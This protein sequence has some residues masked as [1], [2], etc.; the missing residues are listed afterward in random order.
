M[1]ASLFQHLPQNRGRNIF[2]ALQ[3]AGGHLQETGGGG[4]PARL[5][6]QQDLVVGRE[7]VGAGADLRGGA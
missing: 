2:P 3:Q 6:H 5:L 7:D 4:R 1:Q